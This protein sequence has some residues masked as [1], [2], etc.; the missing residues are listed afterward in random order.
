MKFIDWIFRRRG[1]ERY[2]EAEKKTEEATASARELS[3]KLG[4]Y[5]NQLDPFQALMIDIHNRRNEVLYP[6]RNNGK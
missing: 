5:R 1:H 6:G 3:T 2:E 4:H